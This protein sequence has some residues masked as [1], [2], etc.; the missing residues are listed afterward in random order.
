MMAL[1]ISIINPLNP[2]P[3]DFITSSP[4]SIASKAL[5]K[6]SAIDSPTFSAISLSSSNCS[7]NFSAPVFFGN[8]GVA[9]M[10]I[11]GSVLFSSF[12]IS[13]IP[14]CV[15]ERSTFNFT[16]TDGNS[17]CTLPIAGLSISNL[18]GFTVTLLAFV[19]ISGANSR[20]LF[21]VIV[22]ASANKLLAISLN[23]LISLVADARDSFIFCLKAALAT[24]GS[25]PSFA[26][27]CFCV[28]CNSCNL[29]AASPAFA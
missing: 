7:V 2:S 5:P 21:F 6:M 14:F 1:P 26:S 11:V 27:N 10:S 9:G 3:I 4:L 17:I 8:L 18:S 19:F 20:P 25:D 16:K 13:S 23:L 12:E 29:N 22:P 15:T 24:A 28:Y